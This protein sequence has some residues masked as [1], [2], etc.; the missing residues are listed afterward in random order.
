MLGV[1]TALLVLF[2]VASAFVLSAFRFRWGMRL[3]GLVPLLLISS[4]AGLFFYA[5]YPAL[6]RYGV[7]LF[8][9]AGWDPSNESYG[10]APALVGTLLTS[11]IALGA[12][13]PMAVG[14]AVTINEI[15]PKRLAKF[16]ASIVDLSAALPTVLYGLWGLFVLGPFL[17]KALTLLANAVGFDVFVRP[18][19]LLTASLLLSI[20]IT[21]YAAAIIREGYALVPRVVE[22]A[23]YSLGAT[24]FEAV[25]LKLRYAKNYVVGGLF[26][27]LG[28]AMGETVAVSMVVGGNFVRLAAA[29]WDSGITIS[30]LIALQFPNAQVYQYMTPVLYAAA[31]ALVVMGLVINA[32]GLYVL[33]RWT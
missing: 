3:F 11:A 5:A 17:S 7:G 22:E 2:Y 23:I 27:A 24:R 13:T 12:A 33:S 9:T 4:M 10:L 20:M 6:A 26:L 1:L 29:P 15:L 30:S 25:L 31:F 21:P 8:F 19:N 32:V 18:Y 28:R 16:F 14:L